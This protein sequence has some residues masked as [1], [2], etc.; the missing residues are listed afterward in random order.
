[1][2]VIEV[3]VIIGVIQAEVDSFINGGGPPLVQPF[4]EE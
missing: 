3:A 2:L 4:T 1:M